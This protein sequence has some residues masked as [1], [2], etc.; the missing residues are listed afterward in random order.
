MCDLGEAERLQERWQVHREP[1]AITISQ[2]VPSSDGIVGGAPPG[3]DGVRCGRFL[4]VGGSKKDP[5]TLLDQ[6]RMQVGYRS[7]L[8]RKRRRTYLTHQHRGCDLVVFVH[9]VARRAR[10]CRQ[11]PRIRLRTLAHPRSPL[12]APWP[13]SSEHLS[14]DVVHVLSTDHSSSS[15]PIATSANECR[16]GGDPLTKVLRH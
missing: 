15:D 3:F 7:I 1:S 5:I 8:I 11:L 13:S 2:S 10:W 12:A 6:P 4:L 14:L 16:S 9:C